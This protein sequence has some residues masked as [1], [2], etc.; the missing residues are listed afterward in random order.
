MILVVAAP[1]LLGISNKASETLFKRDTG[2]ARSP[3]I[4]DRL[5]MP[6]SGQNGGNGG[7]KPG[8]GS[9]GP[10]GGS[11]GPGGGGPNQPDLE[12]MLKRSQDRLK[13]AMPG[14]GSSWPL[15]GLVAIA[16]LLA[17]IWYGFFVRIDPDQL[18]VVTR[19]GKYHHQLGPGL[20]FRWPYPVERV[21]LPNVTAVRT[22][23][24]GVRGNQFDRFGRVV[25][26]GGE[27]DV[28]EESLMLTGDENIVDVDFIVQWQVNPETANQYLFNVFN[29]LKIV[30]EVSE[31]AIREVVGR[32]KLDTVISE[33]RADIEIEVKKIM[34]ETLTKYKA[35][36]LI[37][38]VKMQSSFV[39]SPVKPS[40]R[41][42][43]AA[44]QDQERYQR[45]AEAYRN[46]LIPRARGDAQ[47]MIESSEA[48]KARVVKEA[49]GEAQ[50]FDKIY[51]EYKKA[52][53]VTRK[54]M[55]LET[56]ERVMGGM[57]KIILDNKGK[58]GGVVPYLPL[59]G[60][61]KRTPPAGGT[62]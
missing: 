61:S 47:Q 40:F 19:F 21:E 43:T 11:G 15:I 45:Q 39:P 17:M 48:Y 28:P 42:I 37:V 1:G 51:A 4:K 16:G 25:R 24:V 35:G 22:V 3:N 38:N 26:G 6:W 5:D 46:N 58:G 13:Q 59:D 8:G 31:S 44:E 50:R 49:D 33:H 34:Q 27:R 53:D 20:Q 60:L 57:D 36:V 55:F 56:M 30:K 29:P 54:R 12:E 18:G 7:W 14:G 2:P 52:P 32:N 62:R 9:G 23:E 41:D 10:W